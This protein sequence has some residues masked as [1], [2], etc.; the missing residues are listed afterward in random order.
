MSKRPIA[1]D[2]DDY[3]QNDADGIFVKDN[4]KGWYQV[5]NFG[6]RLLY[7]II[8][9]NDEV[10]W[11]AVI[12]TPDGEEFIELSHDE[13]STVGKFHTA[14]L[15]KGRVFKGG[16]YELNLLKEHIIEDA[17]PAQ[18][19]WTLGQHTCGGFIFANGV[20]YGKT[21]IEPDAYN[22]VKVNDDTLYLPFAGNLHMKKYK[23]AARIVHIP[24]DLSVQ[25]WMTLYFDTY[26]TEGLLP[27]CFYL[28]SLFRDIA[29]KQ[30]HFF[31]ILYLRGQKGSGK[32]SVARS[33]TALLGYPQPEFNLKSPNTAKSLP[34]TLDQVS[35]SVV[36]FDEYANDIP[37]DIRAL[38]QAVY[39]GGGYQKSLYSADNSTTSVD[40]QSAVILT[41]NYLPE[42]DIFLSRCIVE[43]MN[44]TVK[45]DE[46][47]RSYDKLMSTEAQGLS[48]ITTALLDSRET[49]KKE[50]GKVYQETFDHLRKNTTDNI[51]QR[52]LA[53][54]AVILTP[55]I[56]LERH[57]KICLKAILGKKL[58][59]REEA[60]QI[61]LTQQA[62]LSG[63][64]ELNVFFEILTGGIEA[65]HLQHRIDYR[66][67][68]R[69]EHNYIALKLQ[70][71]V[72]YY[73]KQHRQLYNKIGLP[74]SEI[75]TMLQQHPSY[76]TEKSVHFKTARTFKD[77]PGKAVVLDYDTCRQCFGLDW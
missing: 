15:R 74:K 70:R 52:V 64:S 66:I 61:C 49:I 6:L 28:A 58:N 48:A 73:M 37:S 27:F 75:L 29:F 8:D 1:S 34:R 65:G 13:L 32:S 42:N 16:I 63:K 36:W 40:I 43:T 2:I 72:N 7:R 62:L 20:Y 18:A 35:N 55:A 51:E 56:I 50:W 9:P 10:S 4:K 71:L 12:V 30:V 57:G 3:I 77:S 22:I 68:K 59:L 67:S 14:L 26:G 76:K 5:A 47:K 46:Q 17:K 19:I 54:A 25:H 21:L 23:N 11:Q 44:A 69:K 41:S 33:L 38:L 45:T 31:P 39:D 60:R 53:N 24:V